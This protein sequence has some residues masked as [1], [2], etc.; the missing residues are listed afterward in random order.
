MATSLR[1]GILPTDETRGL[2]RCMEC[3]RRCGVNRLAGERGRCGA[4]ATLEVGRAALHFWEEPPIS[5]IDGS[6]TVFFGHCP[7]GCIYCQN[8]SLASGK[9][10]KAVSIDEVAALMMDLQQQGALNVNMVT[11]THYGP[12]VREAVR[13]ARGLGLVLPIVWN[14][15]GYETVDAV[16]A[17]RGTVDVYLTDF[18]YARSQTAANLSGAADYPTVALAAIDAMVEAAGPP[19]FDEHHGQRRMTG[20]VLVRHLMLPGREDESKEA[21][22]LLYERYGGNVLYSLMNQYTPVLNGRAAAGESWAMTALARHPEL[23][24]RVSGDSYQRLLDYADDL[25][26]DDYF[27]QEGE[28]ADES[29]IPEFE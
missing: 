6:G 25:G 21:V 1:S 19:T 26:M 20:G 23:G 3:P 7:L 16:A 14:T 27:W 29:F 17:N 18:K 12:Q 24:S 8:H 13:R 9:A 28:A 2:D 10:G 4:G 5:G 11:A 15:S 22:A